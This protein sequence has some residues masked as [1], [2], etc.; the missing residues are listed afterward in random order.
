MPSLELVAQIIGIIAMLFNILSYQ[1]KSHKG[2]I[3]FQLLGG[4]L[5]SI[6]FFLLGAVVGGILNAVAVIRAIV[7]LGE[8]RFHS[9]SIIWVF[10][11]S[12]ISICSYILTFTV[13]DKDFTLFNAVIEFLPVLAMVVSTVAFRM[14]NAKKIRFFGLIVSPS[15]LIY[16]ISNFALGAIL[17]EVFSLCSIIIGII[18]YDILKAKTKNQ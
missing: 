13:F 16:N 1:Q 17:C 7:Y 5:F 14:Q 18:R 15:W 12:V 9:G 4:F 6:N 10:A 11:F 8:K 2:V 3:S